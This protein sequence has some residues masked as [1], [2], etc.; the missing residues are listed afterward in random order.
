MVA[1]LRGGILLPVPGS[2]VGAGG[3]LRQLARRGEI[4]EIDV[5]VLLER[6]ELLVSTRW[7]DLQVVSW[8]ELPVFALCTY[9]PCLRLD[10]LQHSC[11]P[12]PRPSPRPSNPSLRSSLTGA[13]ARG[14][15]RQLAVRCSLLQ[16]FAMFINDLY[17]L[18]DKFE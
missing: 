15:R 3:G 5:P 12:L 13:L 18:L 10:R 6:V 2:A 8:H 16:F 7:S 17:Q 9:K 11:G 4:G 1:V 14:R